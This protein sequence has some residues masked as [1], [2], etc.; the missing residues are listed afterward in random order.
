M[1]NKLIE[2]IWFAGFYEGEGTISNDI[3]NN[4]SIRVSIS[5]NDKTPLA[6]AQ[7]RWGGSLRCRKR[8][9]PVSDKICISYEWVLYQKRALIF[10]NDIKPY[11]IIPYK[12]NQIEKCLKR[13][14]EGIT[15]RFKCKFCD[16]D[17]A[18]PS[19]RRRHVLNTHQNEIDNINS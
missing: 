10:I 14:E 12:I 3:S 7:N 18:N 17:Y 1:D 9:S 13:K 8:K 4:N 11:M 2:L 6:I 19:G 15:R 16:Q 5:Q